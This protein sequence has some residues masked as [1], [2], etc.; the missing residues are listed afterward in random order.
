MIASYNPEPDAIRAFCRN[1]EASLLDAQAK[2]FPVVIKQKH[3]SDRLDNDYGMPID[4]VYMG[5]TFTVAIGRP[6]GKVRCGTSKRFA[7]TVTKAKIRPPFSAD[8]RLAAQN[9][10][11]GINAMAARES[12]RS[13]AWVAMRHFEA[14]AVLVSIVREMAGPIPEA[15]QGQAQLHEDT[16]LAAA[17]AIAGAGGS[18]NIIAPKESEMG[19]LAP[20]GEDGPDNPF[21]AADEPIIARR[22][23]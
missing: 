1:L 17:K 6:A 16:F 15:M 19:G 18:V 3:D 9:V 5:M 13:I 2:G 14:V 20:V 4:H 11:A 7:G 12:E 21:T 22:E 10:I 23:E 8:L